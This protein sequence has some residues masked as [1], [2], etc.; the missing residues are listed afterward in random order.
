MPNTDV[1]WDMTLRFN[2]ELKRRFQISDIANIDF[3]N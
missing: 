1:S 2:N 3:S